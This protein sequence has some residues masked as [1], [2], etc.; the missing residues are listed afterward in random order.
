[1]IRT[2]LVRG[3]GVGLAAALL[4]FAFSFL[5]GE[6]PVGRAIDLEA[7]TAAAAGAAEEPEVVSR[8]VQRTVG[9]ATAVGMY[10]LAIGGLFGIAFA[11]AYGRIGGFGPRA[12]AGLL[13]LGGFVAVQLVPF[14]KYPPNPPAVG[15]P[16]T[17]GSRTSLYLLMLAISVLAALAAVSFGRRA[18]PGYGNW[19]ATL[20]AVGGYVALMVVA[21]VALPGVD[22]VAA[23]FPATLLWRFRLASLG[24]QVLLWT[25]LGLLFGALTERSL[26]GQRR[27]QPATAPL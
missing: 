10:G 27:H 22:E 16:D 23:G 3:M 18:A 1:M 7:Q 25:T 17:I 4:A 21:Y 5:V 19:N 24:T 6:P 2:L 20:L 13:A 9:L 15:N 26:Q 12:A 14:L 11:I 8:T